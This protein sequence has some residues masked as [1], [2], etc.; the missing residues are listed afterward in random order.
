VTLFRSLAI[1]LVGLLASAGAAFAG[2]RALFDA[3]G[4]SADGQYFAFEE[5][6]VHDGSGGAYSHLYVVD[7]G[8]DAFV[9]GAPFSADSDDD[10]GPSLAEQRAAARKKAAPVLAQLKIDGPAEIWALLGDGVP[11][12]DGKT[13]SWSVPNCCGPGST[14][15]DVFTLTLSTIKLPTPE[16][17]A[18][19]YDGDVFGYALG[20]S[21]LGQSAELHRDAALPK[22]RGCPLDYRLYAVI[23]PVDGNGQKVAIISS[24]PFGFEGPDRRFL[25]VPIADLYPS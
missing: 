10:G 8:S 12:A 5:Y 18:G 15:D 19:S 20:L 25:A 9:K 17:C 21:G 11:K 14:E 23:A 4:Y 3:V 22:S 1:G 24:Y 2:D 7:L 6:G 13:M 16:A